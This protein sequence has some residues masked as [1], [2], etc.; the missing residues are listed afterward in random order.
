M[1]ANQKNKAHK[2]GR[3]AGRSAREK[4]AA[5]KSESAG[6][7]GRRGGRQAEAA[8]GCTP[9]RPAADHF[10]PSSLGAAG[11]RVSIKSAAV[12]QDRAARLQ[13]AKALR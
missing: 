2:A 1:G 4:H 3:A 5:S 9:R 6:V 11:Q 13:A 8:A 7:S 10:P 12:G